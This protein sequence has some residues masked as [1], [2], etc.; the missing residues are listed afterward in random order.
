MTQRDKV[1]T[2]LRKYKICYEVINPFIITACML[3]IKIDIDTS[4]DVLGLVPQAEVMSK[5][6]KKDLKRLRAVLK[7]TKEVKLIQSIEYLEEKYG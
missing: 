1:I 2:K 6:Y 5:N 7:E 4:R 3:Y